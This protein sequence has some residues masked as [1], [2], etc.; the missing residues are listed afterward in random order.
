[1]GGGFLAK[2]L[3][4]HPSA[5]PFAKLIIVAGSYDDENEDTLGGFKLSDVSKLSDYVNEIHLVYSNDDPY[6]KLTERDKYLRDL[7]NSIVHNFSGKGH[8]NTTE[9]PELLEIV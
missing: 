9:F 5:E 3:C 4:E 8:F 2:Y 7:P 1:M 6:V